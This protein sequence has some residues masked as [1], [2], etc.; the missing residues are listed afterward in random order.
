MQ[1]HS[2][3]SSINVDTCCHLPRAT[4][5]VVCVLMAAAASP[6]EFALLPRLL[7]WQQQGAL[8]LQLHTTQ[9]HNELPLALQQHMLQQLPQQQPQCT[10]H[11]GRITKAHMEDALQQ[12]R[13]AG[14]CGRSGPGIDAYVCG[15]PSMTDDVTNILEDLGVP[16]DCIRTEKWW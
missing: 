7:Q 11:Q 9:S 12:L 8:Q 1:K 16:A 15:P 13:L 10:M 14:G 2:S 3:H 4:V 5:F 6:D